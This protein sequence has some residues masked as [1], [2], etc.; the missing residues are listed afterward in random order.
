MPIEVTLEGSVL[1]M[2]YDQGSR[3]PLTPVGPDLFTVY[4]TTVAFHRD[5]KG[6][7]TGFTIRSVESDEEAVR[8]K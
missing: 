3:D 7:V 1:K 8:K 5:E 6:A 4:G 2:K